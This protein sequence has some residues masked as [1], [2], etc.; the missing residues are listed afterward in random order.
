M[1]V[2]KHIYHSP[3]GTLAVETNDGTL[4]GLRFVEAEAAAS[5][6]L[7]QSHNNAII[8]DLFRWLD[9]YFSGEESG[10]M[11]PV[12]LRGSTFQ[13]RVWRELLTI[14]R[15]QTVTY[16]ELARRV[17]CRSAQAVGQAVRRNPIAIV[18]P[19]HRVVGAGGR[20]TGYAYGLD[21]K[22]RLLEVE[23]NIL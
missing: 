10:I 18:I 7:T 20:L 21:R 4:V 5:D 16:G 23:Q 1:S 13:Q 6:A 22:R 15:G 19:C 14:P 11:P 17:G 3:L 2:E 8:S 9:I 12:R